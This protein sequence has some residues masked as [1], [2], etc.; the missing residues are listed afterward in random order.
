MNKDK[1]KESALWDRYESTRAIDDRNALIKYHLPF[2]RM[3]AEKTA[4]KLVDAINDADIFSYGV[5][6]LI[7]AIDK[8]DRSKGI[9]FRTFSHLRIRGAIIDGL[10]QYDWIPRFTRSKKTELDR[11]KIAALESIGHIPT[12]V[13]LAEFL[14]I[15]IPELQNLIRGAQSP[16]VMSFSKGEGE[17]GDDDFNGQDYALECALIDPASM[18][19]LRQIQNKDFIALINKYLDFRDR[20][21]INAYY[22]EG[23]TFKE[24]G[25]SMDVDESRICQ[26]HQVL[27]NRL[28]GCLR[29]Y[30]ETTNLNVKIDPTAKARRNKR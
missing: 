16:T 28:S 12:D 8:F 27:K 14:K 1:A 23:L 24:I 26:I 2:V 17:I 13:E 18:E 9:L 15:S 20:E 10:R 11:A 3:I 7:G 21:I 6:G 30:Y 19:S 29:E 5:M 4:R 22:W 25:E